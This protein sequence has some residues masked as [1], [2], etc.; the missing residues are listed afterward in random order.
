MWLSQILTRSVLSDDQ[1]EYLLARGAK[2]DRIRGLQVT[3]WEPEL[4]PPQTDP[5]WVR[6]GSMGCAE[7][8][9]D[10]L[11]FPHFSSQDRLLG[12][13]FRSYRG[14]KQIN[15]Y[16][17]REASWTPSF[18]GLNSSVMDRIW[19]GVEVWLVEG[20]FDLFA[21]DWIVPSSSVV[22]GC[23]RAGLSQLQFSFL[24]RF[25]D[26]THPIYVCFDEDPPGRKGV[27]GF[28]QNETGKFCRGV[29][30]RLQ[31]K[32][33]R[34]VDVRYRGGKDPGEIWDH[35]GVGGLEKAFQ[36]YLG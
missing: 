11:V 5:E 3:G 24:D 4:C 20:V 28:V 22:L 30:D 19:Q 21:L 10:R 18:F 23:G 8:M 13:D 1:F 29:R 25:C 9:R 35:Y 31:W 34:V 7:R 32:G 6:L 16:N 27:E 33:F 26:R 12:L 36:S 15:R 2:E 17:L 14:P